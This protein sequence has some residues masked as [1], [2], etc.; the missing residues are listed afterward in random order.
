MTF[1][2]PDR[3][4]GMNNVWYERTASKKKTNET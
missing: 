2:C 3:K 4:H 1:I